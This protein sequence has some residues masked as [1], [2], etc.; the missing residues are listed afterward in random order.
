MG[1]SGPFLSKFEAI[2]CLKYN[3]CNTH[4]R[5]YNL[6]GSGSSLLAHQIQG[7]FAYYYIIIVVAMTIA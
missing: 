5:E 1:H 4:Q 2:N 7:L 6:L 3:S